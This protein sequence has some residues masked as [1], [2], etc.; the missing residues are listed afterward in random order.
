M[1][2]VSPVTRMASKGEKEATGILARGVA[3]T[4]TVGTRTRADTASPFATC[5]T[6]KKSRLA[7][8]IAN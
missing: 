5:S 1:D 4:V 2:A 7:A 8:I 3:G 6:A